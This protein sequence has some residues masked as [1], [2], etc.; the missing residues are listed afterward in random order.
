MLDLGV[1]DSVLRLRLA[2]HLRRDG[3]VGRLYGLR[4]EREDGAHRGGCGD[5]V[6]IYGAGAFLAEERAAVR[7]ERNGGN[8]KQI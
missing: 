6:D 7:G 2:G 3:R 5:V 8:S 4:A 1:P